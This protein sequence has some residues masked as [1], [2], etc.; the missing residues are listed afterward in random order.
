MPY[1]YK[2]ELEKVT[3]YYNGDPLQKRLSILLTGETNSGKT[4]LTRTCRMPVHI[5]SFDPGGTKSISDLIRSEKNPS[6]QVIV[7]SSYEKDDPFN[8]TAFAKWMKDIDT[9]FLIKYFDHFG[10]YILD[11]ATTFSDA[12]MGFTMGDRAGEPAKFNKDYMPQKIHIVNY[13]K[14]LQRL[15]CDFILTAHLR[16]IKKLLR[17]DAKTGVKTEDVKY[18]FFTTGDAV[19]T[20]PLLFDEIYV[21]R[22]HGEGRDGPK[23]ELLID[24]LGEFVARSRL[25]RNGKLDVTEPPDIKAL[26]KKAGLD[27]QDKERL[28]V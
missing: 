21:I 15:P 28:E 14:K 25:K 16:E 24:S 17:V 3:K 2:Q 22:G 10:T 11:S 12:A 19:L 20:I 9:R 6:G 26:L 7:D 23:R 1:D 5:D 13:I 18:R 27:W 8:P 4:Y